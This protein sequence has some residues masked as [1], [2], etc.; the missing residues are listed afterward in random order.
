MTS[1]V[2][3]QWQLEIPF[4]YFCAFYVFSARASRVINRCTWPGNLSV[5][6]GSQK[7]AGEKWAHRVVL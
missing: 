1:L 2:K 4:Y 7:M 3:D 5:I 6:P